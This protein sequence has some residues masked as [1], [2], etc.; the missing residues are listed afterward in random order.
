M[1]RI[2]LNYKKKYKC[3]HI[4]YQAGA[5][6]ISNLISFFNNDFNDSLSRKNLWVTRSSEIYEKFKDSC[7]IVYS[8]SNEI[9]MI[10]K[11]GLLG[12]FVFVHGLHS[13]GFTL[14]KINPSL[15]KHILWRTWG[16]DINIP[17]P[18]PTNLFKTIYRYF[19]FWLFRQITGRFFMIGSANIVDDLKLYDIYGGKQRIIRM[20]YSK[21]EK[22]RELTISYLQK[23]INKTDNITR[24]MVG[25]SGYP[26]DKHIEIIDSVSAFVNNN[27]LF[28]IMLPYGEA[29]Y[30]D[31]VSQYANK[32]LGERCVVVRNKLPYGE[33]VDFIQTID[34]AIMGM[35]NSAALGNLSLL[36]YFKKKIFLNPSSDIARGFDQSNIPYCDIDLIE[37]MEFP[38]FIMPYNY[39]EN[40]IKLYVPSFY[41]ASYSKKQ[42]DR[43][44]SILNNEL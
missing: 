1:R 33:Y 25:H 34:I 31:R 42:W 32:V 27:V 30:I 24:V 2:I 3:V 26:I 19:S 28:Y 10:N 8:E 40:S 21:P 4:V 6:F 18:H 20:P 41:D 7:D 37:K 9:R 12:E 15:V 23:K 16:H 44:M 17:S 13:N 36:V 35:E 29:E 22:D 43:I 14:L 11:Y 39:D 5:G 38:D